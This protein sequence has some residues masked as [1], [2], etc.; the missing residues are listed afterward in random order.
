MDY[1]MNAI[2]DNLVKAVLGKDSLD[3]CN[4]EEL[5]QIAERYPYFPVSHFLLAR[6]WQGKDEAKYQSALQKLS[7]FI[8][9]P[10]W[11]EHQLANNGKA[12]IKKET[13]PA[14]VP[15]STEAIPLA[16][17]PFHTVDYFASQGIRFKEEEKPDDKFGQQ[18]KSFTDWLRSMKKLPVATLVK[19]EE[20][21][22]EKKVE[23]LAEHSL[24]DRDVI[25]EAMAEVWEKQG[26]IEKAIG[27]Y[28]K[29][30]LL[31]PSKNAYFAAKIEDLKKK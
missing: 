20:P 2:S 23:E 24:L 9:D 31:E 26:N 27:I 11:M 18:L 7:L 21:T 3:Q 30:S 22:I 5:Q 28:N 25:T 1:F 4:A 19:S 12:E 17:E 16:F 13:H 29:L 8:T 10:V 15:A 14:A 6:K